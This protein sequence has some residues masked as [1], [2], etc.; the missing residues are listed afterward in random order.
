MRGSVAENGF[1]PVE[2]M[3][4]APSKEVKPPALLTRDG[5]HMNTPAPRREAG[6]ESSMPVEPQSR[7][8]SEYFPTLAHVQQ[9]WP[10]RGN[11]ARTLTL[12]RESCADEGGVI[13]ACF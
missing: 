10:E 6:R 9:R 5:T 13:C 2:A 4:R 3:F 11:G 8:M 12:L 7:R 1:V